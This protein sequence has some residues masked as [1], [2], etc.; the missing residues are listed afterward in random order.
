[1]KFVNSY[2]PALIAYAA[3]VVL[4]V[5]FSLVFR[6][7]F[8]AGIWLIPSVF[9]GGLSAWFAYQ[10]AVV[11]RDP[12]NRP[13]ISWFAI[14]QFWAAVGLYVAAVVFCMLRAVYF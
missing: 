3:L 10:A 4:I 14:P 12:V 7:A 5:V 13:G 9:G 11:K 8:S 2:R 1:M 6:E